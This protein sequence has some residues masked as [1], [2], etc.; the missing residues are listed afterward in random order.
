MHTP[1]NQLRHPREFLRQVVRDLRRSHHLAWRIARR[2]IAS[3]Y[4]QSLLGPF[5]VVLPAIVT[6]VWCTLIHHARVINV[7]NL[8][9]PYPAFV[10]ISMTLWTTFLEAFRAPIQGLL[11]EQRILAQTNA[12]LE[13]VILGK[14]GQVLFNFC[15]KLVPIVVV[16]LYYS[17]PVAWTALFSP[18]G[19]IAL[20]V[21]GC[22]LG[23]ALA[24]I[25]MLYRDVSKSVDMATTLWLFLTPV[26]F[27][28]P[29]QGLISAIVRLNPVTPLLVTT[30]DFALL[31]VMERPV[32]FAIVTIVA[33]ILFGFAWVFCR[34]SLPVVI[35]R[36][37][38]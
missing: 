24:P 3:Q 34:V 37:N 15:V 27:P 25:N 13:G 30:R 23:M 2:D 36:A 21:F 7:E 26:L 17:M 29:A 9:M 14:L 22:A 8:E 19:V 35:E 33:L 20:V 11:S 12:P 10:L 32:A 18:L 4:R 31:G 28:T 38:V 1:E 5:L 6:A 16:M